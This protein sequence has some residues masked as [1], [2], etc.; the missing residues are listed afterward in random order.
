VGFSPIITVCDLANGCNGGIITTMNTTIKIRDDTRKK[1]RLLAAML[2][3]SMIDVMDSLVDEALKK[4]QASGSQ[5]G[6]Q[7]S[8]ISKPDPT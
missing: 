8:H 6:V 1:L 7:V 2:D 3:K 4:V 5:E